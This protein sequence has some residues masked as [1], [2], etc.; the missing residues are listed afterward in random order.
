[1]KDKYLIAIGASA[2]GLEALYEFFDSTLPDGVSYVVTMHLY[3]HQ[4]S[5][6]TELVQK[7]SAIE[8]S[9]V[10]DQ[11]LIAPNQ[12]YVMPENK[13]MT[14]KGETLL[15]EKR[16]LSIKVNKSIDLFF[17]SLARESSFRTIAIVLSGMGDDGTEGARAIARSGGT[18]IAQEPLTCAQ[19]SMPD[20]LIASGAARLILAPKDM[21]RAIV[22]LVQQ[23]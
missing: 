12:V 7:H 2:G 9:D 8:I 18:V 17:G 5:L 20:S 19:S 13:V 21:P 16:D 1:M 22:K 6:L 3:P 15:L 10:E 23:N 4:K 11:M 14:I